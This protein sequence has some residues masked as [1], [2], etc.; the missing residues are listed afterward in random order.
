M[1]ATAISCCLTAGVWAV[2][3]GQGTNVV[4]SLRATEAIE[5]GGTRIESWDEISGTDLTALENATNALQTQVTALRAA[6]NALNA[7]TNALQGQATALQGATNT[8]NTALTAENAARTVA[9][10]ALSNAVDNLQTSTAT[11]NTAIGNLTTVTN[12]LNARVGGLETSSNALNSSINALNART[13]D[14]NRSVYTP[15][16]QTI[17]DNSTTVSVAQAVTKIGNSG[18]AITFSGCAKQIAAGSAG[19]FLTIVCTNNAPVKFTNGKGV[20]LAEGVSFSMNSN[21]VI[22]LVYDGASWVEVHRTDN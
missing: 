5:L 18:V 6:T 1:V 16:A 20:I 2:E 22:Q 17:S 14:W 10:F 21:D 4:K 11:L 9:D 8:L 19:Q 3:D 13:N 15:G 7:S 12:A